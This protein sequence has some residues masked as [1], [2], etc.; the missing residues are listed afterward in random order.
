M[1]KPVLDVT[2]GARMMHFDKNNPLV[3]FTDKR[4]ESHTLC[5]NRA[6]EISPD[7]EADFTE[8]PFSDKS[9]KL[10]VFDPPHLLKLGQNSWMA[11]KYGVLSLDWRHMIGKGL[12]ECMRVLDDWGVLIFKWNERDIKLKDV[13]PLFPAPPTY[14][15]TPPPATE[16]QFG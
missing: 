1:D 9:F 15:V 4:T 14:S 10:V 11:K 2:C 5:D 16:K 13:K 8:L 12:E 6:L 3:L 7:I